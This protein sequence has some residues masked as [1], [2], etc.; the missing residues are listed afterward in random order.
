MMKLKITLEVQRLL[1]VDGGIDAAVK[2][3]AASRLIGG[4]K[5]SLDELRFLDLVDNRYGEIFY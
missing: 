5:L 4:G 2:A 1:P 3:T